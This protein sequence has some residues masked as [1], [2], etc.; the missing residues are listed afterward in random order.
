MAG[1]RRPVTLAVEGGVD[2]A[3]GQRVLQFAGLEVD[4]VYVAGGKGLLDQRLGKYNQAARHHSW[5]VLRDMDNDAPCA[6]ELVSRL[7][8]GRSVGM[9]FRIP[10]HSVESWLLADRDGLARFLSVPVGGVPTR[11]DEVPRPKEILLRL[12]SRSRTRSVREGLV[13]AVRGGLR[14]GP[15]YVGL[16]T[17]FV[18]RWNIEEAKDSS[19]SLRRCVAAVRT[20]ALSTPVWGPVNSD[21]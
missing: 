13:R 2:R 4:A 5:F 11:P 21:D 3:V 1:R 18:Q 15:E 17:E 9:C 20:V 19:D 6:G 10:V 12:A 8:P 16:L 7:L 14:V